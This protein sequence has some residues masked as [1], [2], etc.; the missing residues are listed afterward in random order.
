MSILRNKSLLYNTKIDFLFY[1]IFSEF[2]LF[3]NE[4]IL[5]MMFLKDSRGLLIYGTFNG[6]LIKLFYFLFEAIHVL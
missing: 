2:S 6:F 5:F 3:S 4:D 1:V